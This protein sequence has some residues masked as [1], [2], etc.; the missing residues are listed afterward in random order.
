MWIYIS[1]IPAKI[2]QDVPEADNN[3]FSNNETRDCADTDTLNATC[4]R[5]WMESWQAPE[6]TIGA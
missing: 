6:K 2:C 3:C 1:T 4:S 5:V